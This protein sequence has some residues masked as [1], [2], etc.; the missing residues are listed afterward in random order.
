MSHV[1]L[2]CRL[3][4]GPLALLGCALALLVAEHALAQPSA[5]KRPLTHGDYDS[6]RS[7]Q[8]QRLAPNGKYIAYALTPQEG[9]GEVVVR[10]LP[11]GSEWRFPRGSRPWFANI[12]PR[13][14]LTKAAVAAPPTRLAFTADSRFAVYQ[15]T[16]TTADLAR[17]KK[18]GKAD[19]APRNAL[20][21]VDLATGKLTRL[22]SVKD[23]HLPEEGG[24]IIVY[25]RESPT[26][27]PAGP[28]QPK[29]GKGKGVPKGKVKQYGTD[30][31]VRRLSDGSE[32]VFPDVLDCTLSKDGRTLVY[33]VAARDE[34]RNGLFVVSP[35]GS[36]T[37]VALLR[38]PGR[39][40]RLTWDEKQTRLAFL[41]DRDG[42]PAAP[43]RLRVYL[44][45]RQASADQAAR[46]VR[47]IASALLAGPAL[48]RSGQ[49]VKWANPLAFKLRSTHVNEVVSAVTPGLRAG[50]TISANAGLSFSPDGARLFF[51]VA[52]V[53]VKKALAEKVA[54][55]LWH[56]KDDFIQPMQ[57]VRAAQEAQR[58]YGAVYHLREKTCVQLADPTLPTVTP[59]NGQWA[60]G[61]DDRPYRQL[62]GYDGIYADHYLVNL[63]SGAR[64]PVLRK[65]EGP[66]APSPAGRYVLLHDGKDWHTVSVPGGKV[67]NLTA[68]LGVRF[69]QEDYDAAAQPPPYGAAGWT[70]DDRHILLYDRYDVWEVNP[71]GTGA[72]NLTGGLGRRER[73][74]LR[75]M[76]LD[77]RAQTID[78]TRP[79]LLRAENLDTR[80]TGFYRLAPDGS[81]PEKLLMAAR[82]FG[83]PQKARNADLLVL[84]VSSFYDFPDLHVTTEA[85][86]GLTKV[87]DA[88]PQKEKL[89][90]GKS[91]LV[92]FRSLDGIALQ[93]VLIKPE[94]FDARKKYPLLV[95]IYERLSH[96]LHNFVDPRPGTSVN[97]SYYVSNGYV[98]FL[99]DIAYKVG[100]PGQSALK[101]VLPGVQAVVERGFIDE[102][103][104]GIQGHSWGGYQI[105]YLVTQTDRF[106]AASA[107]APVANMTSA[108]GGIRWGSGLPR[109][110]QY[111]RTQ[112]RIGGTL[113]QF[114]MRFIENSALF[115]ADRVRTPVMMLHND[116]D[117]AVP[118]QQGIEFFLALRRL[119]KE[120]YLFNYPGEYHGLRKR[121]NQKDYTVRLQQF[122]DHHLK[123]APQPDW[124]RRGISYRPGEVA[125]PAT[126]A[127]TAP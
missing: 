106:K 62:V 26:A 114:P 34:T 94:N 37:A 98:V 44:W 38:G 59:T 85:F 103:A 83:P 95:Y 71:D 32:R 78:T 91:E 14:S 21:I 25:Q 42:A 12:L 80:H 61:T 23:F 46:E 76:R 35:G 108:Y 33:T 9:D 64:K 17:A 45:D 96:S 60:I 88:N 19:D 69:A 82:N 65:I 115:M 104:I 20:G 84:T 74:Q 100:Y 102:K 54:V 99:P 16:P 27:P 97:F 49:L 13:S 15:I 10:A 8:G 5:G 28:V 73:L 47:A 87:S 58:T 122:F 6:W 113:W 79:L 3:P 24:A 89:V 125:R 30:M 70:K 109:Q 93:G 43:A 2:H 101:C 123:G 53:A 22:P 7:I 41:S 67:T 66:V 81:S 124:M 29:V 56:Y 126:A 55:E 119:G 92:R 111:E 75:V 4:R 107:G 90:W 118:W 51:G 68:K 86:K 31:V 77:P 127:Q 105:A 110:F 117:E 50:M 116:Q 40:T 11:S 52:P 39:Y 57:K 36:A 1:P 63:T 112:S 48:A 121:S 72:R 120:A 18:A